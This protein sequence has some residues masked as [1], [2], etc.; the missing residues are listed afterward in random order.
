MSALE[1]MYV[2]LH[3]GVR[4]IHNVISTNI[5]SYATGF[6]EIFGTQH[7]SRVLRAATASQL[8]GVKVRGEIESN[9]NAL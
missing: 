6:S 9:T 3:I 4:F 8:V 7:C 2:Y 5:T 1:P